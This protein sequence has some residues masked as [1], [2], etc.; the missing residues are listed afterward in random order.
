[1]AEL[2]FGRVPKFGYIDRVAQMA[3]KPEGVGWNNLG[4]RAPKGIVL[5]RMIGTLWGTDGYFAMPSTQALTDFG[6]GVASIDGANN[7]GVILQWADPLGYRS[8]WASGPVSAPYGD[9]KRFVDK[10]GINAVNRDLISLE[11]S[12]YETTP[13]DDVAWQEIVHFCA[14]WADQMRI[15][16]NSRVNPAT[17]INYL[18]FHEEFTIGTGKTCPFSV[19]KALINRLYND[20]AAFLEPY[21]TGAVGA[22]QPPVPVPPVET[23]Q[24]APPVP[25]AALAEYSD[26]EPDTMRAV[27]TAEG[28]DFVFVNDEV[29]ASRKTPRLQHAALDANRIGPDIAQGETFPVRW[30]FEAKDGRHYYLSPWWTRINVE[31]TERI[32]DAA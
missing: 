21:Q 22:P 29:R 15:P 8:G 16:Y 2:Q 26:W 28:H 11:G 17:G 3:R 4:K 23:P 31:D 30:L 6:F 9:G 10:Y 25:I 18:Y 5:H 1:M 12:G 27:V 19:I 14:Y 32:K 20:I 13:V 7:A 24:Y